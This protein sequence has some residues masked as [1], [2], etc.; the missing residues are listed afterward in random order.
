MTVPLYQPQKDLND[1]C[2]K[3]ALNGFRAIL[4]QAGTGFGKSRCAT[5]Q[6][7][8]SQRKGKKSLFV[9]PRIQLI[10]Q[11][12]K[13]FREFDIDHS[14]IAAGMSFNPFSQTHICTVG[15]LVNRLDRVKPDV[16]FIDETHSGLTMLDKIIKHYKSK[17]A[18]IIGLSATPWKL[19]GKGLDTWYDT[20]VCGPSIK[21]LIDNK[22]LSEYRLFAPS[23]PD[24]SG[25]KMVG[26][27][28]AKGQLADYMEHDNVLIGDA[29]KHYKA[30]AMGKL[31]IAFCTSRKHSNMTADAFNA[32]GVRSAAIDGETPMLERRR[33]IQAFAR[34]EIL[35]LTSVDLLHTG[36]DLSTAANMDVTV[37]SMSDLRP[38]Q[39]LSLQSQKWGRVLRRKDY[40]AL[41]F[42]H[43]GSAIR[44]GLP[45]D[46]REWTLKGRESRKSGDSERSIPV[47]QCGKCYFAHRP[48]PVCPNCG[49]IYEIQSRDIE[50]IEGELKEID[51][52]D[53]LVQKKK[54][55][56]EVGQARTIDD[57]KRIAEDRGYAKGW[58]FKMAK[59]RGLA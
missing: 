49:N 16:V 28:Y 4:V 42:D 44:H 7:Q 36:F 1:A 29:V 40:P 26:G 32:S 35:C 17:G 2:R 51:R 20:M 8:A 5:A 38:T 22:Y 6:I 19:S 50:E 21:W 31:N 18:I 59:I 54:K 45:D 34:R 58:V 56:M 47:R 13:I 37:E 48:A 9:V 27:D 12:S 30:H 41:I 43:A 25:I 24:L 23:M 46:D 11:M 55:R 14:F 33:I 10:D 3:A 39:S 57:L 52:N 53:V 15:S